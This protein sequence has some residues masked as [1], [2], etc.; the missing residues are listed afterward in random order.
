M[1]IVYYIP[2]TLEIPRHASVDV[3]ESSKNRV[4]QE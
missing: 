4:E 1:I 2:F 3:L